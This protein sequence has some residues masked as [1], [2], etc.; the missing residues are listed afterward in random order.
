MM[1]ALEEYRA[2]LEAG[3]VPDR[4]E[5]QARYPE[6]AQALEGCLAAL[7]FVHLVA[8]ELSHPGPGP[9]G[10]DAAVVLGFQRATP[11]GDFRLVRE[12]G[13]GG[14]GVVYEAEQL[15]LGRRVALK[16]LPFA[17]TLDARQLQRFKNE[18]YAAAQLH[19]PNI[20]PV[21]ATGCERGVHYYAMQFI[22]GQTVAGLIEELRRGVGREA[23]S[24]ERGAGSGEREAQSGEG[25]RLSFRETLNQNAARSTLPAPRSTPFFP[26]V[27][28][29]GLQAAQALEHAHRLNVVHRDIKPA[30]LLVEIPSLNPSLAQ[31]ETSGTKGPRLWVT[32]FGLAHCQSQAALTMT[33]DLLGTLRYMSP[34]QALARRDLVDQ[35]TD[36]YSLG[37][38]LYELL[39]LEPAFAG[40]DRQELLRQIAFEEP[41]PPRRWNRAIPAEL[42]TIVRKAME[43]DPADRYGTAQELAEDLGCFLEDR[44]IR[45]RRPTLLHKV[46]KWS[47]RNRAV[48]GTLLG[49]LVV[50]LASMAGL[51]V[52]RL[53]E[54]RQQAEARAAEAQVALERLSQANHLVQSGWFHAGGGQWA[55]ANAAFNRAVALRPDHSLV[56]LERGDF[57]TRLGLW[58]RA[59][60]DYAKGFELQRPPLPFLWL[61]HAALSLYAGDT[62]NHRRLCAQMPQ[63]FNTQTDYFGQESTIVRAYTLASFP[64][65]DWGWALA[66]G[67]AMVDRRSNEAWSHTGLAMACYRAGR[68]AQA[69]QGLRKSLDTD[70]RWLDGCMNYALLAMAYHRLGRPQDARQALKAAGRWIAN[71]TYQVCTSRSF[72][73]RTGWHN[74]LEC[75]VLYREAS[76]LI[77]GSP[78]PWDARLRAVRSR[79]L[80][81]LGCA[82]QAAACYEEALRLSPHDVLVRLAVLVPAKDLGHYAK[83]LAR[84]RRLAEM[85]PEAGAE[86]RRALGQK[87]CDL[88]SL[89][90]AKRRLQ[91]AAQAF[92]RAMELAPE[93]RR[94]WTERGLLFEKCGQWDQA[95]AHWS[96]A[97]DRDPKDMA[98][99]ALLAF[100]RVKQGQHGKAIADYTKAIALEPKNA[101]LYNCRAA[102]YAALGQY[103]QAIADSS[104]GIA[105]DPRD[106]SG[107]STRAD[108]HWHLGI[109]GQA[110]V[111][112]SKALALDPKDYT[113]LRYRGHAY[114]SLGQYDK[115]V[116]DYSQ[117]IGVDPR[118]ACGWFFRG[119]AYQS[120]GRYGKAL[121]DYAKAIQLG[122]K[123]AGARNGLA[124]LLATCPDLEFRNLGR[125]VASAKKAVELAPRDANSW[126]TLGAALCQASR[127]K[128][129]IEALNQAMKLRNGGNSFDW[130]FLAMA[131][132][133]LGQAKEA[134]G[135]YERATQWM[136]KN[137][138]Q[139]AELRRFREEA[140]KMLG[141]KDQPPRAER[142]TPDPQPPGRSRLPKS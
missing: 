41:Q 52:W 114:Q 140:G 35:R 138:S 108:A 6:M 118:D 19:H 82:S 131:Y 91:E 17:S 42:E 58:D 142:K 117:M 127:Y 12:V 33:G 124:W 9:E 43:K 53:Q 15:S 135:W 70:P 40:R 22:D 77:D 21:Y 30:N 3:H 130:F 67:K 50:L 46:R 109:H 54:R 126:N 101:S 39:T 31:G 75:V 60:K 44:P 55:K 74:W 73:P 20:V 122:P 71:G 25:D 66:M 79:A 84:L 7:E 83:A 139:N 99:R 104:Q 90:N 94:A 115:A 62:E 56:W 10:E 107:W 2:A 24:A 13:R 96:K 63:H 68:Y 18:A 32:D 119:Q 125:A 120:L 81:A 105:L 136:K 116:G 69:I 133:R 141:M 57:Y 112:C 106:A 80:A 16:V 78:P 65:A 137:Q 11:L 113:A 100:A 64:R 123:H 26:T 38:T 29:L 4:Q 49:S 59:A 128:A 85:H 111:D 95:V 1:R 89:L 5:F 27:A 76:A 103:P 93:E 37:V 102:S 61:G 97:I 51:F 98:A 28:Q 47:R 86:S 8:P 129:A 110:V 48:V 72:V 36:I 134:R 132:G 23:R 92:D 87:Y 34:E 45:A 14:M 88:G 121:A